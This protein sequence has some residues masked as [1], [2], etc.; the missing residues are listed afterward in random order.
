[1][2]WSLTVFFAMFFFILIHDPATSFIFTCDV[3]PGFGTRS[4]RSQ[5]ALPKLQM[6][7]DMSRHVWHVFIYPKG[8]RHVATSRIKCRGKILV[9]F[10]NVVP[11]KKLCLIRV[12]HVCRKYQR[13]ISLKSPRTTVLFPSFLAHRRNITTATSSRPTDDHRHKSH[14]SSKKMMRCPFGTSASSSGRIRW[15]VWLLCF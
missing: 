10:E 9:P 2:R 1:M 4:A 3:W 5:H 14:W 8:C 7:K 12:G 15:V 13:H 6:S 11:A